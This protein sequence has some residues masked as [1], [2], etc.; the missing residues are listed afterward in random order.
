M[1][2]QVLNE[3]RPI[4]ASAETLRGGVERCLNSDLFLALFLFVRRTSE[5]VD[6]VLLSEEKNLSDL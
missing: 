5:H 6:N 4:R 2:E 3:V 1:H